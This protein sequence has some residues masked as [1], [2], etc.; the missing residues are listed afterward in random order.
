MIWT[1]LQ[2]SGICNERGL[3][4]LQIQ[5]SNVGKIVSHDILI[6]DGSETLTMVDDHS[7]QVSRLEDLLQDG[8]N[9]N[10]GLKKVRDNIVRISSLFEQNGA[11]TDD[12]TDNLQ[13]IWAGVTELG[14]QWARKR[15]LKIASFVADDRDGELLVVV[16]DSSPTDAKDRAIGHQFNVAKLRGIQLSR[17]GAV[18]GAVP[19]VERMRGGLAVVRQTLGG[20]AIIETAKDQ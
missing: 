18:I 17:E 4:R 9:S 8:V 2:E 10:Y 1:E 13:T 3:P 5:D 12:I 6:L 7:D 15:V 20:T 14:E 11:K 19:V 16:H